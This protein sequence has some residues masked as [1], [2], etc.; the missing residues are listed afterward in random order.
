MFSV[1][2]QWTTER[3][4]K[5]VQ[6]MNDVVNTWNSSKGVQA[7]HGKASLTGGDVLNNHHN[8]YSK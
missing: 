1:G 6:R 8:I 7:M 2:C 4:E 5:N 3:Q